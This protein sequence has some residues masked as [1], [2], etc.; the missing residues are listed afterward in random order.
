MHP[1]TVRARLAPLTLALALVPAAHAPLAAQ[2][3]MRELT[4]RGV[5]GISLKVDQDPSPRNPAYVVMALD[6]KQPTKQPGSDLRQL[7]PGT[8]T[9]NPMGFAGSPPEPGRVRFDV[10][11]EGQPWSATVTRNM[12]TTVGAARFFPDPITLPRYLND[13]KH[14][15]K[16]YVNDAT[17]F[18]N[19]FGSIFDDG[20][21]TYVRITGPVVLANNVKRDLLCRGGSA[22]LLY[23]GGT[24]A[25]NNLSKVIITYRTSA[26]VPG[27][28]G[29]GL[30][31]G[32]CAWTDRTAMPKE[33]GRIAFITASN[34]Q[35]KQ[36]QSGGAVDRSPT[37]AERWP[38]VNTIPEY[39][40]DPAHYWRFTVVAADPDSALTHGAWLRDLT[41]VVATGRAAAGSTSSSI[42]TATG[43]GSQV[44]RP[45]GAGSTT[46]ISSVFDIKN[47]IVSPTL[48]NLIIGF[49]AA[50]NIVPVVTVTPE[51]G[52]PSVAVPVQGSAQGTMWRYV[53][54]SRTPLAR[55][56]KYNYTINAPASGNARANSASGSFKTLGQR[57]TVSI[58]QIYLI[59][60]GDKDSDGEV[61]FDFKACPASVDG[62]YLS[63]SG[64]SFLSWGDGAHPTDVQLKS[65]ADV[66]DRFR[67][68]VVGVEDDRETV[69]ISNSRQWPMP[70][71]SNPTT[72]AGRNIDYEWNVLAV[73][74]DLAKYPGAKAGDSFVKRSRLPA[75]GGSL[76]F[77]IRGSFQVTRQ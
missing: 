15:W 30:S 71:C 53:G 77:E 22:G 2:G 31:A 42:P 74:F 73:D 57:I 37:A 26:N 61:L 54:S 70:T 35:L 27:P 51:G 68:W 11:R 52:G 40:K 69:S 45:G 63:G 4:C 28:S 64:G 39:L 62:Y 17:N 60:D 76:M 20:L 13:P 19:S 72:T 48:D 1:H 56:T 33:P 43:T 59:S 44:Y 55:N 14:Y 58:S 41:N 10:Q 3:A 12:D 8:C 46:S 75:S 9:W 24:N 23:G 32:S 50:P 7:E 25:G 38:D 18:S 47:V 36:T 65:N 21:P 67:L 6:Y 16:F 49:Q 5:S 66:P 29:S 34:A